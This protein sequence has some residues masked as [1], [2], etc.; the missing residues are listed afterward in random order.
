MDWRLL[1]SGYS[2]GYTNMAVDEALLWAAAETGAP[3]TLRFYGWRPPAVS[4]GYFQEADGE[5]D[6]EEIARRGWGLVR[7]PTGGRAIL[8]DD[9]VTYSVVIAEELLEHG[10]S[11]M[12]S[13]REISHGLE[14]GLQQLGLAAA[15]GETAADPEHRQAARDLPT[16]CFAQASRCDLVAAGRKVV[17][18]AQVR[19]RG[20]ILQH[21]SVPLTIRVE[22]QL[23]VMPGRGASKRSEAQLSQAAQG[24]AEA[25]G[26]PLG[27]AQLAR[28]LAGGFEEAFGIVLQEGDL[29]AAE[30]A[31]A[32]QLREGK[33]AREEWNLVR[34]G[35]AATLN[36]TGGAG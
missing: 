31:K 30:R 19:K 1:W 22:D 26:Q 4:L 20:V 36:K 9:E 18:S 3:P 34:P 14:L 15:L 23:A 21:G 12:G 32:G 17:G 13:Y 33:Y 10:Q 16:V 5:V 27:F 35:R 8:H 11:V 6:R 24:I 7:R 25:L 29:T 28:A 2:D